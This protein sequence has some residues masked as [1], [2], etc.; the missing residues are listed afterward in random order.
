M[1]RIVVGSILGFVSAR[2]LISSFWKIAWAAETMREPP[3]D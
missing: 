3:R 1:V 2:E